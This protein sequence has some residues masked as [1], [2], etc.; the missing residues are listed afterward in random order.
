MTDWGPFGLNGKRAI[1]TGGAM[2]IGK[3][4]A[5]KFL[6]G[7]ARVVVV[8]VA[9]DKL[10]KTIS[11]LR[12]FGDVTGIEADLLDEG[13]PEDIVIKAV[14]ILGGIDILVNN[15]G[16]Y[17]M[18]PMME[19]KKDLFDKVYK[20]N[21]KS[22]AFLSREAAKQMIKQGG[23]GKIVNI[24]SIDSLHP[25]SIGLAAYDSS[26]GGVL[27][28]TK[29]FA[30]EVAQYGIQVNAI[31]PGAIATEGSSLLSIPPEQAKAMM[32]MFIKMIPLGRIGQPD[33]IANAAVFFAS[34]A[35]DYIT[36]SLLVIDG[37]RLLR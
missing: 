2:G 36:G 6:E 37:G 34:S 26:K 24:A 25:S 30:L 32:E 9:A 17:P 4:I 8:D 15:A 16:I 3:G 23:G 31:A 12:N 11:E 28:F 35:A 1:V 22:L 21:L 10:N 13:A 27:M 33:D 19:M 5:K 14:K 7:G 20:V 18:V 29:N